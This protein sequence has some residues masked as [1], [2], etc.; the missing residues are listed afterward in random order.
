MTAVHKDLAVLDPL[1]NSKTQFSIILECFFF[2]FPSIFLNMLSLKLILEYIFPYCSIFSFEQCGLSF[3]N[4]QKSEQAKEVS[5]TGPLRL[6]FGIFVQK[7]FEMNLNFRHQRVR[8]QKKNKG[9]INQLLKFVSN[10]FWT[11]ILQNSH[12][13]TGLSTSES[14]WS[15]GVRG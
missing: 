4:V 13:V 7:V 1:I 8:N 6:L 9:M 15:K 12:I 14:K 11:K 5:R 3:H 2:Y 10:T